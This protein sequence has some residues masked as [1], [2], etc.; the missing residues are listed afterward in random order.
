[1]VTSSGIVLDG[2]VR[3]VEVH[4]SF[5]N[6]KC[7]PESVRRWQEQKK[8]SEA[9]LHRRKHEYVKGVAVMAP[10]Q[11]CRTEKFLGELE[12]A[13]FQMV[14]CEYQP[15]IHPNRPGVTYHTVM[16]LFGRDLCSWQKVFAA[17]RPQVRADL[18]IMLKVA[19]WRVRSYLNPF[20]KDGEVVPDAHAV[21]I[22]L[23]VRTPYGSKERTATGESVVVL[24]EY[25]LGV[26]ESKVVLLPA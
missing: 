13:G 25:D 7:V 16:F 22:N 18:A 10:T 19:M 5:S 3:L 15:R 20:F 6:E 14:D 17:V 11:R 1:M 9:E 24:P 4:F 21:S 2:S 8:E 23:E 12:A 26:V